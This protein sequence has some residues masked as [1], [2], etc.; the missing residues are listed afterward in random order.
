MT[1]YDV[2]APYYDA[3]MGN[4]SDVVRLIRKQIRRHLPSAQSLLELGCGTGSILEGLA[5][6]YDISG[7]ERSPKMLE[8][9]RTKLPGADLYRGSIA[10]YDLGRTFD[11]IICVFDTINHLTRLTDWRRLLTSTHKHLNPGGLFIFDMNTT[12]RL[13]GTA[14]SPAYIQRFDHHSTFHL[15]ASM[16]A[17]NTI[18]WY[19]AVEIPQPNGAIQVHEE[20]IKEASFPI[21]EVQLELKD[22]GFQILDSFDHTH[23]PPSD[24]SDRVYFVCK[25]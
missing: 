14:A 18:E 13:R 25:C 10:G 6:Y 8:R 21:Q 23:F 3:V 17:R 2:L 19:A 1:D 22:A 15:R 12:G 24:A 4:R 20:Y 5:K 11:S 9:A 16:V 7:L